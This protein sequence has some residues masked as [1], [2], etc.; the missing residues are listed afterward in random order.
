MAGT[1]MDRDLL[2]NGP[3]GDDAARAA[4][5]LPG[6]FAAQARR[7]PG[8]PAV[9]FADTELTY[10]ELDRRAGRLASR[11]AAL[12]AGPERL[13][14]VALPRSADLV[15]AL[16]AVLKTG[17]AYLPIDVAYPRDRVAFMLRD[18]RP[19]C[20]LTGEAEAAGL[21]GETP[22]VL[23]DDPAEE[24]AAAPWPGE[25][26]RAPA[27]HPAYV[28]YTSGSTG[29]PKGV[30]VGHGA[31]AD[32]LR[33]SL[34]AYP[35]LTGE[36]LWHSSVSF[37]MTV[38]S[39]WAPLVAG[40]CVRVS[41]LAE[42]GVPAGAAACA[43]LKATPSHLPLLDV[44]PERFSP[45][46]E[47]MF[48]GEALRGE[49]LRGWRERHPGVTVINV[50]GPTEAT[51]NVAEY[52][53][54][55]GAPV[56]DGV[57]P[58]GRPMDDTRV[59]VLDAE[60]RPLPPGE[61]GEL[62]ISGTGLARGYV[63]RPGLTAER[64]V[65]D[66]S[67]VPGERMYRTGDLGRWSEDGLLEFAG[68]V[69]D[70]IKVRGH[71]IEPGEIEAVLGR[72]PRVAQVAVIVRE[73]RVGDQ[74]IVAY[75]TLRGDVPAAHADADPAAHPN[76]SA[77]AN[78]NP[79]AHANP[80]ASAHANPNASAHADA[81]LREQANA[82][83]G[84]VNA[85]LREHAGAALPAY[86]VPS[87]VVVLDALPLTANGKLDRRA[88]PAPPARSAAGR[89]PRTAEEELLCRLFAD[90][91]GVDGVGLDGNF[92]E[93]GGH[94]L[95]ATRLVGMVRE[96]FGV[97]L[98]LRALFEAP[99][100][101]SLGG[102]V[103]TAAKGSRPELT[104]RPRPERMPLSAGQRGL[105]FLHRLEGP[106]ATYNLPLALRLTGPLDTEAL[107]LAVA[108]VVA[109]HEPLRTVYPDVDGE[110]YQ[111]VLDPGSV[112]A[113]TDGLPVVPVPPDGLGEALR[114]QA[115]LPFA[116]TREAP[117]RATLFGLGA[118]EH[119]LMLVTHHIASD[120]LSEQPLL[121]DLAAAYAHRTGRAAPK[122]APAIQ[123]ADHTLWQRELLGDPA[124]ETSLVSRQV[125]YWREA[126]AGG[127]GLLELPLDRPRPA[128]A[129]NG[130]ARVGFR[131]SRELHRDLVALA[132]RSGSTVFMVVQAAVAALLT[133]L[134]AG[135]DIP[136]GTATAGRGDEAVDRLVGKFLNTLVL[137]TD[138]SGDPSF[139]ELL[140]RVTEADL[141]AYANADAPYESVVEAVNPVRSLSYHPVFQVML[142]F[143][144][145]LRAPLLGAG[146]ELSVEPTV[147][148]GA[149]K[150][151][152]SFFVRE[153]AEWGSEGEVECALDYATDLFDERSA[154]VLAARLVRLLE[155][156]VRDP[157]LP[158]GELDLLNP[159]ERDT[160]LSEW[161]ATAHPV[162][163]ATLPELFARQAARTPGA[164]AVECGGE[165]LTYAELDARAARLARLLAG[166]GVRPERFVAVALPKSAGLVVALLAIMKAGG[167]YLPVDPALP[168]ERVRFML[169][170]V[171]PVLTLGA[172]HELAALEAE[173]AALPAGP[174][175][176][177]LTPANPAF[178]IY[179]SGSTGRPKGVVVEHRSLNQYL[180][181]TRHT[182]DSVAGRA[183]VHSPVSFDLTVT[184]LFGPLTSGGCAHLVDLD[185]GAGA[186]ATAR[187]D[188]VKATPSH[189]P[190]LIGLP[191][192][193]SP[194]AQLVLGG[195][196][197]M[198]EVLDE[199][200]RRHPG[201][202]VINE[203]GPTETTVGCMEYRIEPGDQVPA[204][205]VPIGRPIWNTRLYVLD[206]AL[207]PVPPGVIGEL[208][209]A[210]DLVSRGYLNRPGLSAERFVADPFA[211][212]TRMYRSG[213]L[214]RWRPD[215]QMEFAGRVDHQ[216]KVRGFRIELSEIEAVIGE[217]PR[218]AHVAVIVRE[219]RPG[220]QRIVAYVTLTPGEPVDL[221]DHARTLLPAYMV[222]SAVVVLD[223]LPLT[224]NSKLDRAALPAPGPAAP[225]GGSAPRTPQQEIVCG[226]FA[227]LLGLP[228]VG[229]DANFFE[230]GGH[231]LLV[232][233]LVSRVRSVF[234]V[235]LGVREAFEAPTPA[236]LVE[237]I[238]LAGQG[239]S[240]PEPEPRPERI[241]LSYAQR[242]VW[243]I[244]R[245][246][247]DNPQYNIPTVLRLGGPVDKPALRAAV[248]D[249]VARH[250]V[251]RTLIR[252]E[253]GEP[254]QVVLAPEDAE[255]EVAFTEVGPERLKEA[256][257]AFG[258]RSFRLAEQPPI[259]VGL[260]SLS[261]REHV[262]NL[263]IHHVACDGW[264]WAALLR[265]LAEAYT[266]RLGQAAPAWRPLPVQYADYALWQTR[267][268]GREDEPGSALA[269]QVEHWRA[270][271]A[272]M[273]ELIELPL[274][275]PRPAVASNKGDMVT[276]HIDAA[277][278]R[279]LVALAHQ[280]GVTVFMVAHAAFAALLTRMGA[281]ADLPIGTGLA[282]RSHE[283]LDE[284]VGFFV[285]TMVL[286]T[287]TSGDPTFRELLD[288]V[289]EVDLV[290]YANQDIPFERLVDVVNPARSLAHHPLFQV[291]IVLQNYA[292]A[293]ARMPGLTVSPPDVELEAAKFDLM[294]FLSE[295]HAEDPVAGRVPG[296]IKV[297]LKYATD[298]F[299]R[300][301]AEGIA[302][303][304]LRLLGSMVADPGQRL[305][306]V[307]VLSAAE[308]ERLLVEW[309]DT[310]SSAAPVTMPALFEAQAARTPDAPAL[311]HGDR[312]LTYAELNGRANRLARLLVD[313]YG[314]G[315]ESH[316]AVA[317][318]RSV[319]A[320]AAVLAVLKTGAAYVP[321]DPDYPGERIA[322][323]L[324]DTGPSLVITG[325]AAEVG[326]GAP[327]LVLESLDE[328]DELTGYAADDLADDER[329][330]PLEL[331]HPA[332]V[333]YT[334][335]STGRPKGVVV[336]H[337]GIAA[338]VASMRER[339]LLH[340]EGRVLQL[341]SPSFDVSVME[342]LMAYGAGGALVVAPPHVRGGD[343]LAELLSVQRISHAVI[344]ST[345]LA[346]IPATPLP[347][348]ATLLTGGDVVGPELV[349]RWG[350]GRVMLNGYG[351]TEATMWA[352]AS[353]ALS[354]GAGPPIGTPL[355]DTRVYVLDSALRPVAPGVV[356]ELYVA[357][358]GLARG[359]LRRPALTAERFV[360][361]P[362]D[363]GRMY[364]TGDAV[365]WRSDGQLE[366][367]GRVDDQVKVRG[368]R[369]ELGEI[370]AV[371]TRHP[372]V[373]QAAVTVREDRP[374][375]RRIVAY[376]VTS[377]AKAPESGRLRAHVAATLPE[378]MVPAAFVT[379][380]ALPVM[381]NGKL[382]RRRLP[383]PEFATRSG[384]RAP[385]TAREEIMCGL[386]AEILGVP[387]VGV[388]DNFFELG[389]H[390]L[391]ATRLVSR[392]RTTLGT[393]LR[394][395]DLFRTPTVA[396]LVDRLRTGQDDRPALAP[397]ERPER[398]PLSYAQQRLWFLHRLEGP[399][400]TFNVP[401]VLRLSG[402]LHTGAL[403]SALA[404]LTDR[405]ESLRTVYL[406][407]GG[408]PYQ[409]VHAAG[410]ARPA[411]DVVPAGRDE[412]PELMGAALRH[413]FDLAGDIPIR[414]T[415]F[416]LG[417]REHCLLLLL[418]HIATD[419]VSMG[420]L[421]HD[422]STAYAARL[423]GDAPDWE[424]L[425]VQYADYT[426]WQGEALGR[427]DDP[428]SPISQQL[429]FWRRRLAGAPEPLELPAD[430]SR[431]ARRHG[432]AERV[433]F[434]VGAELHWDLIELARRSSATLFMVM[435]A[436]L[437]GLLTRLGSGTDITIGTGVAG[438]ADE[439]LD[440]VVG[441]FVNMVVLRADTSGDPTF[442]EL[443]D[444]VREV[445][446]A[447]YANADVPFDRVVDALNPARSMSHAPLY[448]VTL[449]VDRDVIGDNVRLPGLSAEVDSPDPG[450]A[451]FDLWVGL[452]ESY[453]ADGTPTGME[454]VVKFAT[455]IFD[456]ATAEGI[457]ER[458]CRLLGTVVA[459][460]DRRLGVV[461]VLSAAERTRLLTEW[462]DTAS[463]EPPVTM[464]ALF[465]AWAARTPEAPA[466]VS[467]TR[468]LT[469]AEVNA[470]ANRLARLLVDRYGAGPESH[471]AVALPRSVEAAVAVLAVM[472]AGA[473]YV[474]VDPDYP[475]ER[476]ALML[477]D[478][479][480]SLVITGA[481]VALDL[482]ADAPRLVLDDLDR[483]DGLR[484]HR[485]DDL[486]DGDRTAPLSLTSPAYVIYTSGSTG[487][488]KGVVVT[489]RGLSASAASQRE[490]LRTVPG[491]RV[492]Q[493]APL[494]TDTSIFEMLYA[495]GAGAALV[496]APRDVRGGDD[497][498]RVLADGR[499]THTVLPPAALASLP[500]VPLPHLSTLLVGTD[501]L[502][503]ELVDRWGEGRLMLNGY[504]PTETSMWVSA[505]GPLV[506]GEKPPIGSPLLG[507]RFYVLDAGLRLV[508]PGVVGELYIAGDGLARGYL[509]RPALTA[510]RFVADPF[511]GGRMY[512][513]GDAV[514]W[515][516]D[517]QLEFVG[518]VDDQVK[519]RGFRIELGEI[520][521]VLTRHHQIG[522][523]AVI[524]REDR[525]G[526]RRIVAYVVA[527]ELPD[528][529]REFVGKVLPAHMVPSAFV[530]MDALP[531]SPN[532]KIDRRALP[533]P[534]YGSGTGKAPRGLREEVVCGLFAEVLGVADV[535]VE[536]NFF[537]LG[538][539][540]LLATQ[541]VSRVR[542]VLGVE[543]P[544]RELFDKPTVAA[545]CES[546]DQAAGA[547][548]PVRPM[549]RPE[550][551]PLSAAQQRLWFLH[552][553]EGPSPT[554]NIPLAIRLSG[555]LDTV[556][557]GAAIDDLTD[558]HEV[559]RTVF[560]E[561]DGVVHQSVLPAL[562]TDVELVETSEDD[563]PGLLAR[564]ITFPLDLSGR[565]PMRAWLYRTGPAEH[566]LLLLVH[567]IAGDGMSMM[568]L[569]A[570]LVTAY[571]ARHAGAAPQWTPLPVQYADYALWQQETG[572]DE[573]QVRFWRDTLAGAPEV[574]ELPA[575]RPRPDVA[576]HAGT[577]IPVAIPASAH[578]GVTALARETG[579]TV[580]MVLQA[581]VAAL[582]SRLGAGTD[583]PIGTVVAG[584]DD[585]AL[586][587]LVGFFVNSLVLRTDVSGEPTFRELL[588]RV[589]QADL[590]AYAHAGVPFERVVE[591]VN[592]ERS[593]AHTPLFQV[594]LS[595]IS[596]G[597]P[598]L[599]LPGLR[600]GFE[601]LQ[602]SVAK[603]DLA[604]GLREHH[605]EDG[606]PAGIGGSLE[607]ATDLF[608]AATAVALT[609]RLARLI[610]AV[611][612]DPDR[613]I[614][615][616]D[617]LSETEYER[618]SEGN[619]TL[620]PIPGQTFQ[621]LFEAQVARAPGAPALTYGN[622]TL[623]Y[624]EL[625]ERAN[626]LARL[627]M[628]RGGPQQFVAV[629][630]PPSVDAVVSLL[631]IFKAGAVYL[632]FDPEHPAD[633]V[634][635]V[636][637]SARPTLLI[638]SSESAV[639]IEG[640]DA[641]WLLLDDAGTRAALARQPHDDPPARPE[642]RRDG[643]MYV[644][645]TSGS[646]G[647]P[648][649]AM[650]HQRGMINHLL[651]KIEELGVTAGDAVVLNA[652][653]TFDVS[654]W[655]MLSALLAGG[656][657]HV[658]DKDVA[659]DP[660]ELFAEVERAGL[661][662]VEVVPS[663]MR[664]GLDAYDSGIPAPS[665]PTLR[666][667]IVNGEVLS[668]EICKRWYAR[669]PHAALVNAYGLTECSD[670]NTH[671]FITGD[672]DAQVE[673]GRLPVG[674]P[675]RN[676]TLHILDDG[677]RPVPPGLPGDLYIAG[678]GVGLGYL[679][680]PSRT[681]T[682][683]L[684]DPYTDA[685]GARMYRTGD[686]VR[687]RADG[688]LDFL[689]RVDHQVKIR[690][691][692]IELG[693]VEAALRA[694]PGVTDAVVIA[695]EPQG[696][697]KRLVG[698]V[699]TADPGASSAALR[700]HLAG[701][702]PDYMVPSALVV[703]PDL[704][705]T[706]NG[707]IDR[708]ALPD[709]SFAAQAPGRSP[710][711]PREEILCRL[712]AEV[713][714]VPAVSL[715][716][717]FFQ[718]GGDSIMSLQLVSRA[719]KAGLT[720]S[721]RDVFQNQ[722]VEALAAVARE[723]PGT[724]A[725]AG[726]HEATGDLPA[727][728]IMHWLREL[729]GPSDGFN[730]AMILTV[731]PGLGEHLEAAVQA[732]FDHHDALRA[733]VSGDGLHVPP[734]GAVAAAERVRRVAIAGLPED[735]VRS[736]VAEEGEVARSSLSPEAG[737]MARVVWFD[738]GPGRPGLLLLV[739][740]HLVV[741]GV[742]WR[743]LVP[744][745]KAAWEALAR[746][747]KP[748]L[749]PVPTSFR[750]WAHTLA[751]LARDAKGAP[752]DTLPADEPPLGSRPLD[753]VKDGA[754][755]ARELTL[756]LPA[757]HTGP[758]LT[759]V[760][761]LYHASVNDVL[762]TGLAIATRQW[763]G[764]DGLLVD[765]E[766]HGR[767][768]LVEG[769][770]L[771]RTVGWFTS[772]YPVHLQAGPVTEDDVSRGGPAL[773]DALRRVKETLR[774]IPDN[775]VGFGLWRYLGGEPRVS[776]VP[777]IAF[778][779]L[780]RFGAGGADGQDRAGAAEAYWTPA[781]GMPTPAPRDPEMPSA[782]A[783]ELVATAVDRPGG[784][785]LSV[786]WS[787]PG[788]LFTEHEIG[789]LAAGWFAALRGLAAHAARPD[790]GGHTPSDLSMALTQDEIDSLEEE[791]MGQ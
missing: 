277:L 574:L 531:L 212:G 504:G 528:G 313:R 496:I 721:A 618:L 179:T 232:T 263:V 509:G 253:D 729:G 295:T 782:H 529:L 335:G 613:R 742:S 332:Y 470:L 64:F 515:R 439:A 419:G 622:L 33:W 330:A 683:Y 769:L 231:S 248:A 413:T 119:V 428:A 518:R 422:L 727:T 193:F 774:A 156:A 121:S 667:F 454:G 765:V 499:V 353:R 344:P 39:L 463:P 718:L 656:R 450:S 657:T 240:K 373:R 14:A 162:P 619:A 260:F 548:P 285:N 738:A 31:L 444:R 293:Q 50:Y 632:P 261:E 32:Y 762:L 403:A 120:G 409:R 652:P 481:A 118:R 336:T 375:D 88:L 18:A 541:L 575:D 255:V 225:I 573:E 600:A 188:F 202:T 249:V 99:T 333:I 386:F 59:H 307:E 265:D 276:L 558:R 185:D 701:T 61:V 355:R 163:E 611:A 725:G 75:V 421:S 476:I 427:D 370:E 530:R 83:P 788:E 97:E 165:T 724:A 784:A 744:D 589:R 479:R 201:A 359:Y 132:R 77:H 115:A 226:L 169:D 663:F 440:K 328:M 389:G 320:V 549:P 325:T 301:S 74:R 592:P 56:P 755:T 547:R 410:E 346:S 527:G 242:G 490:R 266:A 124:E 2:P 24:T 627:L 433:T 200:R 315:P 367:V 378:Y 187:P 691:N 257:T 713:V 694:A 296:G 647:R 563:L 674:R 425:P 3:R 11:L 100:P 376:L 214:A 453:A 297:D 191:E 644:I 544:L 553:L 52:R 173:A 601:P 246:D 337:R 551:I 357:G 203:Y 147:H 93:L 593:M 532:R 751:T 17:A 388:E 8:A 146:L 129:G 494:S 697:P 734:A 682:R 368:F 522:Q 298:L 25:R 195:E 660:L 35:S 183:L 640:V 606:T 708:K 591:A 735:R 340:D 92:F 436:A 420:T 745:L 641:P 82:A 587:D 272:G 545:L 706:P 341:A 664:A 67:G 6:L 503:P 145:T 12:G 131:L 352:T 384:G 209:I 213:D 508:A 270:A 603:Y 15:V 34:R 47:L 22:R 654:V 543:L 215:G 418:H 91:L 338:T 602:G 757:E 20:V 53:V 406:D 761:A 138:T 211:A 104:A 241:P 168:A 586:G 484:D 81:D 560:A 686:R 233:R 101:E 569:A 689:T 374:G 565:P 130:G 109:R 704:P 710:R 649:G 728:P 779:Y 731:P 40:G 771:S 369:I 170:D 555:E 733:R 513:T 400:P 391:L 204:G 680:E 95:L 501:V 321:V 323:M 582:L 732:L 736:V 102:R 55:P 458:L 580:F 477:A 292:G 412:L 533:V 66:P 623:S 236:A 398:I 590:A 327:R 154:E 79:S 616:V 653:L 184:G 483:L 747:A 469:Y 149:A 482:P 556:A 739:L 743:I 609:E 157:G 94:S 167:A 140:A 269:K 462:N 493:F 505:S 712:F 414:A 19:V 588:T 259:R 364:R 58:L 753:P 492:L 630:L 316:V 475:G 441:F 342:L 280:A 520:E 480:P 415:L 382:D 786:T 309:N 763:R 672:I 223:A 426:L 633:R 758:L 605:D 258:H 87:A 715:D 299:E 27:G 638:G 685:P 160:L 635:A 411:F 134:G 345:T 331:A 526:D 434:Q 220:D 517:G 473:A 46:R 16:L 180:A 71:R 238:D 235:E 334:S 366:F 21:P 57:L 329:T 519:V 671:A 604:F 38:T 449:T 306:A 7:T 387:H 546:L 443:L 278:H 144:H 302:E 687:L 542:S 607:Y 322:L 675:L 228:Q 570:D 678:T 773:G 451:K 673:N 431:P 693:E 247:E 639:P 113:A 579:T 282:G 23:V 401:L 311:V 634:S 319:E 435:H 379:L 365:R 658:V 54:E 141:A 153:P 778:N 275:R 581:A 459:D 571:T 668:P 781:D 85:E 764:R 127:P 229:T 106:S 460:P 648:K 552:R 446:L 539:H 136:I 500:V 679:G 310:A 417:E 665:M 749:D 791:L 256:L 699:V 192:R 399:S 478:T 537:E 624:A 467:G 128:V 485:A 5:W 186:A 234:G 29:L 111:L 110:P 767:E 284:L 222:P 625:N 651:A 9:R 474:P 677:L 594:M 585:E 498:A 626:R 737:A 281:G 438:R 351:P 766:A 750:H 688:Q 787:W 578:Q 717:G 166:R 566:V 254:Y 51:V 114:A 471:V 107:G 489:H 347:E 659:R 198:G 98:P 405:H 227:E 487:R 69:D 155:G 4:D 178:V 442:R 251:L 629:G 324:A 133:R 760:P 525:P 390:S 776:P 614:A 142:T 89:A 567:H 637:R 445:D 643:L 772:M 514:R 279:D 76:P 661:S 30:V 78:P 148:T 300:A 690:G 250:E 524:V 73:D 361:D 290:A 730:Q 464:P 96:A 397:M 164:A 151:D 63:N 181:W 709:P 754:G 396:A 540:S 199:W 516:A 349:E 662:I 314:A 456:R 273:P 523:A 534:V 790:A 746:G 363:G 768:E 695:D 488:P 395:R 502:G 308:R 681:A 126:L 317:L 354:P 716:D 210:G 394:V 326:G 271:L 348:L 608:D 789:E 598:R 615:Q 358:A 288:R 360:A 465:E 230:L 512:R 714:G 562:H 416:A 642:L 44:L 597:L 318:P 408:R 780:G 719:R 497:L 759:S 262:L 495:F 785:E 636:L 287:D 554:Y 303:R 371:L 216:V 536:D 777:Q 466:L 294:F 174:L 139:R 723:T 175:D 252:S 48:G 559:L 702:L 62:Y 596:E 176:S 42:D 137:R 711:N 43:F 243:F 65:P 177:G 457:A 304:F 748:A 356:G 703:L 577:T 239:R 437:A 452:T 491:S 666:W 430:R 380:D 377:S 770:D 339:L 669:F 447:A 291:S 182:Y 576:G 159:G 86:M 700:D 372:Q 289:R 196:S 350:E 13:V 557:L 404:D 621:E 468:T 511:D 206:A 670:D 448:Q 741:D 36:S 221:L 116:F 432:T 696:G 455:D 385:R 1:L 423:A 217:H 429:D 171:G 150:V 237:R 28:I 506:A 550:R 610:D 312:T 783:I 775:G 125:A 698:Y 612:A 245:L 123:Y 507:A 60:L 208:Y 143:E 205:V 472:K 72:H 705:L 197:L 707:K 68:R 561:T 486:A 103:A 381:P 244:H 595:L 90:A 392:I 219:D 599:D 305:G 720:I 274:D 646:T 105:W 631:A 135:A 535:G 37:D 117:F 112:A 538:G 161:N 194:S 407:D 620:A 402:A 510:E 267:I 676:N 190:L 268:L 726:H 286:R 70:Q 655:Q 26:E 172:P 158:I 424:P 568:P 264:S 343:D 684:P 224:A 80:N 362:F 692:R 521:A 45:T 740:H 393:E 752:W 49:A 722:T 41:P 283:N 756:T 108:D 152:L 218:V 122:E 207:R 645:F 383:A 650:V 189:L 84:H 564:D 572:T 583:I 617:L 584:R 628:E 10:A 461:E